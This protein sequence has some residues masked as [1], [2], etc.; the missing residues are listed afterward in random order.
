MTGTH[1]DSTGQACTEVHETSISLITLM[2]FSDPI[3]EGRWKKHESNER[4][5]EGD[6]RR[7]KRKER[8]ER[9]G[10]REEYPAY[11]GEKRG[12][13]P[14]QQYNICLTYAMPYVQFPTLKQN[15]KY[16]GCYQSGNNSLY[17]KPDSAVCP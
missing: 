12:E 14:A 5:G 11:R 13:S 2:L 9:D 17:P 15:N 16:S 6:K 7:G 10:E 3:N 1:A 8:T 4:E